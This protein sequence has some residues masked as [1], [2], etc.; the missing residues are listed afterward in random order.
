MR[1]EEF[2]RWYDGEAASKLV[3]RAGTFRKMFEHLDGIGRPPHVVETGCVN[4]PDNWAG[5]GCST[6]LFDRY[7]RCNPGA[8]VRSADVDPEKVSA[9]RG[10]VDGQVELRC[11]DSVEVLREWASGQR[12]VDLVYLDATDF[13]WHDPVPS[14]L[15]H[16][17]ELVAIMPALRPDSMVVVDDSPLM[18]DAT[19][20]A[21]IGG[22]GEFVARYASSVG[23]DLVFLEYQ[24]GWL[25]MTA[26]PGRDR[27]KLEDM[28]VRAR[29]HVEEGRS[30]SADAIYRLVLAQTKPPLSTAVERVAR[31]EACV[32][33]ARLALDAKRFGT[34]AEWYREALAADPAATDYRVELALRCYLPMG[35]FDRAVNEVRRVT[36]FK[37]DDAAG[38]RALGGIQHERRDL[39]A[40]AAAYDRAIEVSPPGDPTPALDRATAALDQSDYGLVRKLCAVAVGTDREPDANH[41]LALAASRESHHEEAIELFDRA[42]AGGCYD[43]PRTHWHKSLAMEAVG[44]WPEA[45]VERAWRADSQTQRET[46]LPMRRFGVPLLDNDQRGP[47][48]VHVHAEAGSGDNIAM[49]RYL[50][51]IRERGFDVCF[52]CM[53][54]MVSLVQRSM[55]D[56]DVMARTPFY[57]DILGAKKFDYHVPTGHLQHVFRTTLD[58]VPWSGAYLKADPEL[59]SRY[60]DELCEVSHRGD[61]GGRIHA[62]RKYIGLCWSSGIRLNDSAW[63]AEYGRRKSMHLS[64]L[65]PI[66]KKSILSRRRCV[67][68]QVGPERQQISGGTGIIDIL[69]ERPTWDDTAALVECLDLVI[70]VDTAVAHLAGALGKPVWVMAPRDAAS[71]HFMCWRPGAPWNE[72]S[73]WYPTARVFR[74]HEFNRPH[75]WD[76]VVADVAEALR[77]LR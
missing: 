2:W 66:L 32:F 76:E 40:A 52:E 56:V 22:K 31:G 4:D 59:V 68:L 35:L 47:G 57:P 48:R 41:L 75:Y 15:H 77:T 70:T 69:P 73:P 21:W 26:R 67:S 71:W 20:H 28:V 43:A 63:L 7:A 3:G 64:A 11:G 14:A 16:L 54:D 30:T 53:P 55:P 58:T 61:H 42:I 27:G 10:L 51:L 34:S 29:R 44:R 33:F 38:W 6:I 45:W 62:D 8:T 1:S 74:Q 12:P 46:A 25:N 49:V 23:A 65:E 60:H 72:R 13:Y 24:A 5:N 37:P 18:T 36:E 17:N 39:A 19:P 50:P 9:A